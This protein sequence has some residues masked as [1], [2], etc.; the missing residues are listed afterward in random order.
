MSSVGILYLFSFSVD[1][2]LTSLP[3]IFLGSNVH[4]PQRTATLESLEAS[5]SYRYLRSAFQVLLQPVV[6]SI[7]SAILVSMMFILRFLCLVLALVDRSCCSACMFTIPC[8]APCYIDVFLVPTPI[9]HF[10]LVPV[11]DGSLPSEFREISCQYTSSKLLTPLTR[12]VEL[13]TFVPSRV[14]TKTSWKVMVQCRD[15]NPSAKQD[16][17]VLSS[18]YT[19]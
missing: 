19:I 6:L 2:T 7:G 13:R 4:A 17:F 8:F 16:L 10:F 11:G 14:S 5:Q 1:L 15:D 18:C 3:Q 12:K 9:F